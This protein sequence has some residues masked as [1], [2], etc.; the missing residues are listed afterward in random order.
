MEETSSLV[1]VATQIGSDTV[2]RKESVV[3][4]FEL[5]VPYS[6]GLLV[7][8]KLLDR[9]NILKQIWFIDNVTIRSL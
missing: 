3:I 4:V 1:P 7:E 6:V 2:Y 8:K 9:E 5:P